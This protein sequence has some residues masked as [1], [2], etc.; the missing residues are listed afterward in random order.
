MER[1]QRLIAPVSGSTRGSRVG[2]RALAIANFR[3][4]CGRIGPGMTL[5]AQK[6]AY[7]VLVEAFR[8]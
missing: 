8:T 1:E 2:D 4:D 6:L 5:W 7:G 3:T